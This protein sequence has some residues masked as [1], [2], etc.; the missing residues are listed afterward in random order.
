[1]SAYDSLPGRSL[2]VVEVAGDAG[3]GVIG[4]LI[5]HRL[6]KIGVCGAVVDG[7]VRDVNGILD[8]GLM[9]WASEVTISGMAANELKLELELEICVGGVH[10]GPGD[11]VAADRD[12]I[13]VVPRSRIDEVTGVALSLL[14]EEEEAHRKIESG[15]SILAAYPNI[16]AE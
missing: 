14:A 2:L 9:V 4:D 6:A 12:G 8:H 3:G 11:L 10:V 5:A 13:F 15:L 1:M 16:R 7:P